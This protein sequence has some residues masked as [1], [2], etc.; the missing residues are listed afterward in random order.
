MNKLLL[1]LPNKYI[2][3]I[4]PLGKIGEG[5][6]GS[7]YHI[8][9]YNKCKY[10]LKVINYNKKKDS[11]FILNEIENQYILNKKF[12]EHIPKIDAYFTG[13][14]GSTNYIFVTMEYLNDYITLTEY[15]DNIYKKY[16]NINKAE[17]LLIKI[18]KLI[19]QINTHKII[20]GDLHTDN[21]MVNKLG[22]K[23]YVIDFGYSVNYKKQSDNRINLNNIS[24]KLL[25]TFDH[26]KFS[27]DLIEHYKVDRNI[28]CKLMI[29][30]L[31]Y[32]I[33]NYENIND[34]QEEWYNILL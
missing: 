25:K 7:V 20:H 27:S 32:Y 33:R 9:I 29:P 31:K 1:K 19:T 13:K 11:K 4:K 21:I 5:S 16:K 12:P 30:D 23:F 2:S 10:I 8:C 15:L 14:K 6:N 24:K 17:N 3:S 22:K 28:L 34:T 18:S 26:W